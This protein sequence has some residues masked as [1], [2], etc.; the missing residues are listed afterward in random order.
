MSNKVYFKNPETACAYY[1]DKGKWRVQIEHFKGRTFSIPSMQSPF[2]R[3]TFPNLDSLCSEEFSRRNPNKSATEKEKQQIAFSAVN[4]TDLKFNVT[5]SK[6][7][8]EQ[9]KIED[10]DDLITHHLFLKNSPLNGCSFI[11]DDNR[12]V[13]IDRAICAIQDSKAAHV[14]MARMILDKDDK[15]ICYT[16][17]PHSLL[18]AQE[19]AEMIFLREFSAKKGQGL[20]ETL[21]PSGQKIYTLTYCVNSLL[22]TAG[23][24]KKLLKNETKCLKQLSEQLFSIR[25][26]TGERCQVKF[27][28]IL[29]SR[30]FKAS[31]MQERA[32]SPSV[33]GMDYSRKLNRKGFKQLQTY[34][35]EKIKHM[36][37]DKKI[38][39]VR[40]LLRSLKN[41][42]DLLPEEEIL[43]RDLLCRFLKLP[44]VYHCKISTD[45]T[46][47]AVALSSSVSQ[48]LKLGNK[49]PDRFT[50]L[51]KQESFK[52]LFSAHLMAGHQVT[53]V[54]RGG[55][56]KNDPT[57]I[58]FTSFTNNPILMRLLPKRYLKNLNR[59]GVFFEKVWFFF[60]LLFSTNFTRARFY[61]DLAA[62]K[63]L[64]VD[65]PLVKK[66][67][68]VYS[69]Q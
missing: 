28:P 24:E 38:N 15:S 62:T 29:F 64:N 53:H 69:K 5:F 67:R 1:R 36:E 61:N 19:Q 45:R 56:A 33:T 68:L 34:A 12:K 40:S 13:R 65:S 21:S 49:I 22:N 32:F 57:K 18:S 48:W 14:R 39:R 35:K 66:R 41:A 6:A 30:Q 42:A 25:T 54:A 55:V 58:G 27:Q 23:S 26:E 7:I 3:W 4:Q 44:L 2:S 59:V 47:I 63:Q 43:C 8:S 16:G 9:L 11:S 60:S 20:Q 52:E 10:H 51:L 17:R 31:S 46:G 37:D 50:D